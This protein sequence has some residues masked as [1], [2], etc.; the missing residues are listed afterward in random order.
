MARARRGYG[1]GSIYQ[2][3][4]GRWCAI[5]SAGYDGNGKRVRRVV[6]GDTKK[7]VGDELAK[8]QNKKAHG[9]L[10]TPSRTTVAGYLAQWLK[11]VA[12]VTV[13]ATTFYNYES[14]VKN[15]ISPRIGGVALQK[16][17]PAHV[18]G[19][20]SDMEADKVGPHR[21]RLAH[22]VLHRALK[23]AL[24]WGMVARNVCDAV[25]APRVSKREM[26]TLTPEQ[27]GQLLNA[28]TTDRMHALYW[29]ALGTGLRIG[30]LFALHWRDVDLK[31]GTV[32]VRYTLTEVNG[33]LAL[34]EPKSAKSR[35]LI[36]LP[37]QAVVAL[38]EHRKNMIV[39][40]F[41]AVEH[42]FCNQHGGYLRRSHFH[43][44]DYKPLLK[45]A[46]LP[47]IR[48]HDLRHTSATMLLAQGVHPKVVQERLGHSQIS[49]T[50]DTYSHVMPGMQKDAAGKLDSL[51][52]PAGPPENGSN[53]AVKQA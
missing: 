27:A 43:R 53:M 18:Q 32:A 39:E 36:D 47:S 9:T 42:V 37:Q 5:L 7:A 35:R 11:D 4:D 24:K 28:S 17:M 26:K 49:L 12:R 22:A 41:A 3:P 23:Q 40:G 25:D 45:R 1:E 19:L 33:K 21:R 38:V 16:L 20:Y 6:Y 50:M 2:R 13:R 48:F 8:L 29:L 46:G 44:E 51:L 34:T 31:A 14:V 15:H 30:E 10:T 52:I